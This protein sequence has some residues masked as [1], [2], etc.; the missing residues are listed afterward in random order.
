MA[1]PPEGTLRPEAVFVGKLVVLGLG[2]DPKALD[3]AMEAMF[4]EEGI[5]RP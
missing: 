4:K 3:K 2:D 5:L 1:R